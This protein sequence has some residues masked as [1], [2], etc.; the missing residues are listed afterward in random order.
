MMWTVL[1]P[2]SP[3]C[4]G[5]GLPAG[6]DRVQLCCHHEAFALLPVGPDCARFGGPG[7]SL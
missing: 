6:A 3:H 4:D 7:H 2:E 1:P 5:E